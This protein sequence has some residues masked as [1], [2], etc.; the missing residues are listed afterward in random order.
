ML[1]LK[2]I[3]NETQKVKDKLITRGF[4]TD[5]IDEIVALAHKRSKTIKALQT[6][7]TNRNILTVTIGEH[8]R[9]KKA[10]ASLLKKVNTLKSKI[11]QNKLELKTIEQ[12]LDLK[13][14]MIPNLPYDQVPEGQGEADNQVINQYPKLGRGLVSNVLSH[15]QIGVKLKLIDFERAVKLSGSRFWAYT[16]LGAKLVR[17]LTSFMLDEHA[18]R[19]YLEITPPLIVNA[20]AS[21]GAGQ[22]PKFADDLFKIENRAAYLIS[23]AE[24]PLTSFYGN[25]TLSL[26][27]PIKLM[28]FTPCFRQE[29]GSGGRDTKGLI[30]GH[31]FY[32]VELFK[33]TNQNDAL[34]EYQQTI[35]DAKNILEKLALPFREVQL[36]TG[37]L[38]F[39]A[40]QTID[41]EVWMP[42]QN[43]YREISSISI[44]D[45]FQARRANIKY[46]DQLGKNH[47]AVTINGSGLAIDRTIAAILE[48]YQNVDGSVTIPDVLRPYF[49]NLKILQ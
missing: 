20:H 36:C 25:E 42:S 33:I 32:K 12:E 5:L 30:R 14:M 2:L 37:D 15:E 7:E 41:L 4:K 34:Q 28:A 39:A 47:F 19:G 46:K 44:F 23:T 3:V 45:Q 48:N 26:L 49:N 21:F 8:K 10:V 40:S 16:G 13:T 43:C 38:G 31:Q 17:A 9:Q 18:K 22:L 11:E 1:N 24:V 6:A 27:G 35:V 29:A